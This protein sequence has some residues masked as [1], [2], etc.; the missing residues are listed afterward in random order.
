MFTGVFKDRSSKERTAKESQ[1]DLF[2]AAEQALAELLASRELRS[3]PLSRQCEI[4]P[5]LI[6]YVFLQRSLIVE[7][8][9]A[10]LTPDS[11]SSNRHQAR[12]KFLNTLGYV[13]FGVSPQEILHR[14][15]RVLAK[16]CATLESC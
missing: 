12:I 16:L 7:L 10:A 14:P 13:V 3:Y 11:I 1:R 15:Q 9:P 5:F 8:L 4:G 6:D 2:A